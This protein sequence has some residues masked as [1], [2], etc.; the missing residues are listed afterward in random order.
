[1]RN[2]YVHLASAS[3]DRALQR[4]AVLTRKVEEGRAS[5]GPDRLLSDYVGSYV[6][7]GGIFRIDV[8]NGDG[9][10][11]VLFQGHQ[12]Q[13]YQLKHH[14]DETELHGAEARFL[15]TFLRLIG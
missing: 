12:S 7:V 1:V 10:L 4:Y 8:V 5:G 15:S 11:E 9:G 14:H 2:D 3:A 13:R 6:G